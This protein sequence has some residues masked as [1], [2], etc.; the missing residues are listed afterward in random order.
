MADGGVS[1]VIPTL[2]ITFCRN[3]IVVVRELFSF[4]DR[5]NETSA[6]LVASGVVAMAVTFLVVQQ[7][8]VLGVLLYGFA[9]RVVAGPTFSPLAQLVTRVLTPN[10][11]RRFDVVS[12]QVAGPPK[13]FAQGVGLTFSAVAAVAWLVGAPTLTFVVIALLLAAASLE[14]AAGICLGCII[15]N[16][17]WG[18]ADCA[19]ISSRVR[20]AVAQAR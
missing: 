12:R 3:S 15:Y 10:L 18:C 17:I 16:A 13:R 6:R 1:E 19:D 8:W 9:A 14:A 7:G 20:A 5:I 4:P 11:E 2:L